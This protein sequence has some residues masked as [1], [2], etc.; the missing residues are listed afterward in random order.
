MAKEKRPKKVRVQF[1]KN[2]VTRRREGD[3]TRYYEQA[4]ED[5]ETVG[6]ESVRAKGELSR[7]RTVHVEE[8]GSLAIDESNAVRGRVMAPHG[9]F[10]YVATTD[11]R[12]VKC[13]TRRLLKSLERDS[14]NVIA[15]GDWVWF[16]PAHGN[17]GLILRVEPRQKVL[18]RAYRQREQLIA[19]NVDQI[20]I[21]CA[22]AEPEFKRNLIDR[23]LVSAGIGGLKALICLNKADLVDPWRIQ[24]VLGLYSQLGYSIV[25]TS[26]RNGWGVD[27]L[28]GMLRGKETVIVG[29]SGVGKSSLLNA[30]NPDLHL[31]V[32]DVSE[33]TK[34]GKHTT[35]TA[36]LL[37][38][39]DGGSVIDT[40]GIR[41]FDVWKVE[42]GDVE[43]FFPE[44]HPFTTHC[45]FPG[46]LHLDETECAVRSAVA[47]R[48]ISFNRYDS[49][50]RICTQG[51]LDASKEEEEQ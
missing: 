32:G 24:P 50:V 11:G 49:Y 29:Q 16:R 30:L 20:L 35:T 8:D 33:W 45:R 23:Y 39:A 26:A 27:R 47:D 31:R 17:E 44:F 21:V 38:L 36:Q 41:Q 18:T 3:L 14:R 1:Q 48:M 15:S 40:P 28:R 19:A 37:S 51:A 12:I 9:L 43:K 13:Y 46:C 5:E 4:G 2:R 34:K 22:L 42:S 10:C 25:L 6:S 7:K